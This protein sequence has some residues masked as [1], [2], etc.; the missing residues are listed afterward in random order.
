MWERCTTV[1]PHAL[2]LSKKGYNAFALIYWP[3]AQTACEDLARAISFIFFHA[4]ELGV[5]S[6]CY[7]LWGGS[8]GGRMAARVSG[9]GTAAFGGDNLPTMNN[10]STLRTANLPPAFYCW[11]TR[12][13]FASQFTQNSNAVREAGCTVVTHILQNYPHGYGTGGD[14]SIW[15]NAFDAFLTPIMQRNT[16]IN[17]VA[18]NADNGKTEYYTV[19]GKKLP[20]PDSVNGAY[21][22]RDSRG[23][24]KIV[25]R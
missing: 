6:D 1:F 15:G 10:V 5:N 12:D 18:A 17:A 7:S 11:G 24:K 22:L 13:G 14:T 4:D 19:D 3:G 25:K 2:E 9:Y 23:G 21:I 20:S 8:A 16:G